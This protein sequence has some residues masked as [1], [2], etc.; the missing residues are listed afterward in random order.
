MEQNARWVSFTK[1]ITNYVDQAGAII[2]DTALQD[3][4]KTLNSLWTHKW[5]PIHISPLWA[6]S[7]VS[8]VMIVENIDR[9]IT[10]LHSY[11]FACWPESCIHPEKT[12]IFMCCDRLHVFL[13]WQ[14]ANLFT[15]IEMTEKI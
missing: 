11:C 6:R 10:L 3:K 14:H 13:V 1:V 5:H 12:N 15:Y 2:L 7:W 4:G 8:A 9:V